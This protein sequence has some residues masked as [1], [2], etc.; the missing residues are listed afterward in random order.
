MAS[1]TIAEIKALIKTKIESL[2]DGEGNSIFGQ[3]K[4][5]VEG[6]FEKYPAVI[7]T[8]V[9]FD[10]ETIDTARNERNFSFEIRLYQEQG[11]A[12]KTKEEAD[13][14][15]TECADR[16]ITAFDQDQDLSN[17]IE[18]VRVIKGNFQLEVAKGTFNFATFVINCL[19]VLPNFS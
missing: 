16:I 18:K 12:G 10:G 17:E 2:L 6:D 15:M 8:P 13:E 9:E 4:D 5:Y 3:V 7:I 19:V 11:H 14:I 1:T